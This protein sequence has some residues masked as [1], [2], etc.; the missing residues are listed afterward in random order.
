MLKSEK[1]QIRNIPAGYS[2]MKKIGDVVKGSPT[3]LIYPEISDKKMLFSPLYESSG[4]NLKKDLLIKTASDEKP[5]E[6]IVHELS[7][8]LYEEAG[9]PS[10]TNVKAVEA[11]AN[12]LKDFIEDAF[13]ERLLARISPESTPDIIKNWYGFFNNMPNK[14]AMRQFM[15]LFNKSLGSISP[16]AKYSMHPAEIAA[17]ESEQAFMRPRDIITDAGV[18]ERISDYTGRELSPDYILN[19]LKT[20]PDELL[21]LL[22]SR[23]YE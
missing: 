5:W 16:H 6:T 15:R 18:A 22:S 13:P 2:G 10:G 9:L 4:V 21:N 7:H 11:N 17:R 1:M 19:I 20:F 8:A 3:Q 23:L 12:I 14:M